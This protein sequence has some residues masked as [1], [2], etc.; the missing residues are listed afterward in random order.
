[1]LRAQV[2]K[3]LVR[4]RTDDDRPVPLPPDNLVY[5]VAELRMAR[6][7]KQEALAEKLGIE[8]KNLRRLERGKQ[9]MRLATLAQIAS[10][11]GVDPNTL[12]LRPGSGIPC[13]PDGGTSSLTKALAK[14]GWISEEPDLPR[15]RDA[16]PLMTLRAAASPLLPNEEPVRLAWLIPPKDGPR[17]SDES[18]VAQVIGPSMEPTIPSRSLCLFRPVRGNDFVGRIVLVQHRKLSDPDTGGSHAVK[19][20]AKLT[21]KDGGFVVCCDPKTGVT[22]R[23]R[24]EASSDDELRPIAELDRVL[25]SPATAK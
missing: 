5:R 8:T 4:R 1:M 18:F 12:L 21:Q 23:S 2:G 19:R 15:A 10:T 24:I 13:M 7:L 22:S 11:L 17:P 14:V 6:G 9:N 16:V 25:W 20:V 3:V